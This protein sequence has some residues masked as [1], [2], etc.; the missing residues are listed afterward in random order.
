[1]NDYWGDVPATMRA[2]HKRK[3]NLKMRKTNLKMQKPFAKPPK[4][5]PK[6]TRIAA[7]ERR[8]THKDI[9]EYIV[10]S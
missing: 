4:L 1:M 9:E 6:K 2:Y 10:G 3:T 8:A 5:R 7:G